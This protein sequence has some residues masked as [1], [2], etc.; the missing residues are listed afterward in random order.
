MKKKVISIFSI[1]GI[2]ALGLFNVGLN[3]NSQKL[4]DASLANVE[5]LAEPEV[6]YTVNCDNAIIM[7]ECDRI[8]IQTSLSSYYYIIIEGRKYTTW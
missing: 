8:K 5:A 4:S 1:T 3:V 7:E 6:G 2:S